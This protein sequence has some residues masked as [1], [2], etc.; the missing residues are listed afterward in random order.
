MI[1]GPV[2]LSHRFMIQDTMLRYVSISCRHDMLKSHVSAL[3]N[4]SR[5]IYR[6]HP[7]EIRH[8]YCTMPMR[9]SAFTIFNKYT[10]HTMGVQREITLAFSCIQNVFCMFTI[11]IN[12]YKKLE[13]IG[14][15]MVHVHVRMTCLY[16][17]SCEN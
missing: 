14:L 9:R 1:V 4:I 10:E 12:F 5:L 8:T 15:W 2:S 3:Q 6:S 13:Q 7:R 16:L 17:R 11:K